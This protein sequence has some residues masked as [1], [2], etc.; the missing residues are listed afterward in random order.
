MDSKFSHGFN[1]KVVVEVKLTRNQRLAHGFT[2]QVEEYAKADQTDQRVVLVVDVEKTGTADRL[3][4][5]KA[6]VEELQ[7]TGK[8]LPVVMHVN[9][10]PKPSAS[11]YEPDERPE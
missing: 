11:K 1:A 5:F 10:R 6:K 9:G 7:T 4:A 8:S 3:V 2:V